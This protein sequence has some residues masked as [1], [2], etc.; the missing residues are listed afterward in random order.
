MGKL[1]Q[2]R[3]HCEAKIMEP[4]PG[5]GLYCNATWDNAMCWE[6]TEAGTIV[7]Q[8]CPD[9]INAF[10]IY[11][12]ATRECLSDG[13][14]RLNPKYNKTTSGWTNYSGCAGPTP[15]PPVDYSHHFTKI[16]LMSEVGYGLSLVALII[17]VLIMIASKRLHYKSNI[18][19]INLFCAFILRASVTFIKTLL[20]VDDIGL[21][22]DIVRKKGA[23]EFATEGTHWECKLVVT[24]LVYALSAS[25]M[26]I[27]MEGLYLHM[28][29]YRTLLT[30]R[31]GTR[32]YVILGW[33]TPLTFIVPWIFVRIF[34]DDELCWNTYKYGEHIWLI[35]GPLTASVCLNFIFFLNIVRVLCVRA[36]IGR[37]VKNDAQQFRK[38]AKFVLVL[39]PLFGVIYIIFSAVPTGLSI[40]T[41]IIYLYGEMFYNSFQGFLLAILF[42]F[43]NEEV[44]NE[45][46]RFWY[47]RRF[48]GFNTRTIMLSSWRKG[49]SR[50][51]R[52][53]LTR[54]TR[55]IEKCAS[56]GSSGEK[57]GR[58]SCKINKN[59]QEHV[60]WKS[61]KREGNGPAFVNT[62][63]TWKSDDYDRVKVDNATHSATGTSGIVV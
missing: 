38:T 22:K 63:V 5:P 11:G 51:P 29:V 4:P 14:W 36:K 41:D 32:L 19:H 18:L 49:S 39:I 28:L 17:A 12:F 6:Y 16:Q 60:T 3:E 53:T 55:V 57:P 44:H 58:S 62:C 9:Y 25:M 10:N 52:E 27:L 13:T 23:I 26:W 37:H 35:R 24:L 15:S 54:D 8:P 2:R 33:L 61:S 1:A 45:I 21:E 59:C 20:F 47:R 34:L 30:E 50:N 42:C 46:R 48:N 43:L 56:S 7:E 31:H 40:Q